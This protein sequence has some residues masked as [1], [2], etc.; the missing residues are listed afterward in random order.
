[1]IDRLV[2]RDFEPVRE[3]FVENFKLRG[4]LGA[5][6]CIYQ[7]GEKVVDL[8]GCLRDRRSGEPWR[9]ETMVVVHSATKGLAEM[10][11]ALGHSYGYFNYDE[12]VCTYWPELPQAGKERARRAAGVPRDQCRLLRERARAPDRSQV[13]QPRPV[14]RRRDRRGARPTGERAS[15]HEVVLEID[16]QQSRVVAID[17]ACILRGSTEL[18][19]A[20]SIVC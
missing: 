17:Q 8:W 5:A 4:E 14:L 3:A 7:D 1:L 15:G 11:V 13:P 18:L 20:C 9:A 16:E 12:R 10:A 2:R 6:C 19:E